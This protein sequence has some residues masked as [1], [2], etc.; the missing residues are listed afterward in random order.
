MC[1]L[2]NF[3]KPRS[4]TGLEE[5]KALINALCEYAGKSAS[6]IAADAGLAATTLT[7]PASGAAATRIS[8]TTIDKLRELFPDF[9][10]WSNQVT[11]PAAQQFTSEVVPFQMEG[12]SS[13]RMQQDVPV[14]GTALGAAE[15]FE[16]EAIEQTTLNTGDVVTYFKRPVILD[17]RA[18]V[19]GI[20]IQG[21]SMAPRYKDGEK[22]FV[23]TKRPP[24]NGDDVVVYLRE[25]DDVDGERDVAALIKE[26]V[27]RTSTYIELMQHNPP[28]TFRL[29]IERYSKVHRIIPPSEWID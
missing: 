13:R 20:F 22:A 21:S 11:P 14:Y 17:G 9:P 8:R 4:M 19:Y 24:R 10:G 2:S 12:A 26:L 1:L 7:R 6:R 15:V 5:D 28:K 27:R 16:G 29:P 3:A 25:P 23:E 18:D